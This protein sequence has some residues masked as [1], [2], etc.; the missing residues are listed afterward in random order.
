MIPVTTFAGRTV[1]ILGL[2]KSGSASARALA[3][4][5]ANVIAWDDA[6]PRRAAAEAEGTA[7]VDFYS[8]DWHG[9]A[10][11]VPSPGVPLHAPMPHETVLLAR[12]AGC[13]VIGDM[14][15]FAR[16]Q[17]EAAAGTRIAAVT[18]T[19]GKSTT[20][21]LLAYVLRASGRESVE[22]GNLGTP[23]L[24][25]P[26]LGAGGTY[27]LELSS[28]QIDL[29]RSFAAD[30][31]VLLNITPDHIDRHGSMAAY[32]AAKERLFEQQRS[33]QIA[34][35][36]IDDAESA[37]MHARVHK[38]RG[39]R[40][41]PVAVGKELARGVFV[42]DGILFD[43]RSGA[44]RRMGGVRT[45]RLIGAHNQQNMAMAYA[46][47]VSLGCDPEAALEALRSFPGLAHRIQDVGSVDGVRFINDSKATNADA[48]A[49][50]LAC[51]DNV[52][53]IAGGRPKEGGIEPLREFFPRI[54]QAFLIGE[55]ADAFARTIGD[56][57]DVTRS[58]T[59]QR[60][61]QDAY[62][63]AS[64]DDRDDPVVLLSPAC[65][66]F[67]Q[68]KNFEERGDVFRRLVSDLQQEA[69]S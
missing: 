42:K 36:G 34:V 59:L 19:N 24:D 57:F 64:R 45:A 5:G 62:A 7:L 21:A 26:T 69:R 15:L 35:I 61:V 9:V 27:V 68:F 6:P 66:S 2:A 17:R 32:V 14:E 67:D 49:R 65:A 54:R 13:E 25:L 41:I 11:L 10:A 12:A 38:K 30:V 37:A 33:D 44:A 55:A 39:D 56:R 29:T 16:Q 4:G 51:F 47:A 1:A 20:T 23:V 40:A 52:Y 28:Y 3:A 46:A 58:G 43:A 63:A 18:G 60:A 50:A 8:M 31:A 53:W 22:G 48:A